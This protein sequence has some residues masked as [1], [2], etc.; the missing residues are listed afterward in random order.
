MMSS[1]P[2]QS[3][4]T[5]SDSS[6][7]TF[8]RQEYDV[9]D[10]GCQF[11]QC[12]LCPLIWTPIFPGIMGKKTLT[13][14]PEEAVL[15]ITCCCYHSNSRRPYGEL[16]SVDATTVCFCTGVSSNLSAIPNIPYPLCPGWGGEVEKVRTIVDEM[17][18]RMRLRGDTGQIIRAEANYRK[19]LELQQTINLLSKKTDALLD[20]HQ[21]QVRD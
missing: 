6:M 8:D 11:C 1:S 15:E 20:F 21:I 19:I 3:L 14:E 10:T 17:R 12:L 5:S 16:G 9:T 4:L 2:Q 7:E 13:L 18:R